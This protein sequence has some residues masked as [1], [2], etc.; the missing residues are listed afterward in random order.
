MAGE[1]DSNNSGSGNEDDVPKYMTAEEVT[2]MV[3]GANERMKKSLTAEIEKAVGG[4]SES[5]GETIKKH[6]EGI[7]TEPP[8]P[9]DQPGKP[10]PEVQALTQK[11]SEM[12]NSIKERDKAL[13]EAKQ[14]G[15]RD[16]A[17]NS[18]RDAL[19]PHVRPDAVD[20]VTQLLFDAQGAVQVQDDGTPVFKVRQS[21]YP[22]SPEEDMELPIKDG[23]AT[24]LKTENAK[25][26][27][28]APNSGANGNNAPQR[29]SQGR[30]VKL[31]NDGLP[32]YDGPA[33]SDEE[34]VRRA[35]ERA[36]ALADK[37]PNVNDN[38]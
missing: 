30:G 26:F 22:G 10:T 36:R 27:L 16:T 31:G 7:K 23:V 2:K 1:Q 37:Y 25:L 35:D 28:P 21:P 33:T 8:K 24:W 17:R 4:V 14:Q 5:V 38:F 15:Q 32:S 11:L 20:M 18:L 34:R 3:T 9:N 29:G 19:T 13:L 6:L 12:E